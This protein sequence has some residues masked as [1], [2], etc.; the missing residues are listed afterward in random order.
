MF[1]LPGD[2]VWTKVS[3]RFLGDVREQPRPQSMLCGPAIARSVGFG[4]CH[5]GNRVSSPEW[6]SFVYPLQGLMNTS[7]SVTV[8]N[9]RS[10]M[11]STNCGYTWVTGK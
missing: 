2:A 10:R 6:I 11:T 3:G 4:R 1:L 7:S 8:R 9:F 5:H